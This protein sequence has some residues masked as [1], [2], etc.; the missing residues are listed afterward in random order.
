MRV[1]VDNFGIL[2]L[3]L[4]VFRH[5]FTYKG[6]ELVWHDISELDSFLA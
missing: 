6:T 2:D 4:I 5:I 3:P 1:F